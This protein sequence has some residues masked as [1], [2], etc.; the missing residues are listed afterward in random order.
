MLS[1]F[2]KL[3]KCQRKKDKI[4]FSHQLLIHAKIRNSTK[5]CMK[6]AKPKTQQ[7]NQLSTAV[8]CV[9]KIQLKS[10]FLVILLF[11]SS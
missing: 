8:L 7:H 1:R 3:N 11:R 10:E 4:N 5:N 2:H 6:K 9:E